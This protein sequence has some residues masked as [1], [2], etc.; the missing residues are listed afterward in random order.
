MFGIKAMTCSFELMDL[1][2]GN[3][4]GS[5]GSLENALTIGRQSYAA[6][7]LAGITGLGIIAVCENGAQ[8]LLF[9]GMEL[10]RLTIGDDFPVRS[11]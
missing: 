11:A 6:H 10:A 9:A 1:D 3:L 4:V 2:T 7:G 8:Q 5:Y